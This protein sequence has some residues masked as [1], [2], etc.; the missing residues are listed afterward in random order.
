MAN[1]LIPEGCVVKYTWKG[2]KTKALFLNRSLAC[3]YIQRLKLSDAIIQD[4]YSEEQCVF[5]TV[6]NEVCTV[7]Q[8]GVSTV[9][10]EDDGMQDTGCARIVQINK[11]GE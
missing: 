7:K 11:H 2:C 3:D 4:L 5:D 10:A 1:L 9:S 8:L 6:E